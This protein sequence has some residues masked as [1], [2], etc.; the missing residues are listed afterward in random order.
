[1]LNPNVLEI[2][3]H[4]THL[5]RPSQTVTAILSG[6]HVNQLIQ[7]GGMNVCRLSHMPN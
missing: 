6:K 7:Y 3:F 1:M 5:E 2:E 4:R